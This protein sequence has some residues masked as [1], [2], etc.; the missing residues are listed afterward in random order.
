MTPTQVTE[1]YLIKVSWKIYNNLCFLY[2]GKVTQLFLFFYKLSIQ[3]GK[4]LFKKGQFKTKGY[5][6]KIENR[7]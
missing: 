6:D 4:I 7:I 3:L 1:R 2:K 5:T